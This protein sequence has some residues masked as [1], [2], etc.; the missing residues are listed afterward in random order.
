MARGGHGAI[1]P[2]VMAKGIP[3]FRKFKDW[4]LVDAAIF[5]GALWVALSAGRRMWKA[6]PQLTPVVGWRDRIPGGLADRY[7]KAGRLP[8]GVTPAELE[9]GIAVELEHTGS[10]VTA[11]EIALDHLVEHPRYYEALASLGL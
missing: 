11:R 4:T 2:K 1:L 6:P 8:P 3:G 9:R 5:G 7:V 10:R